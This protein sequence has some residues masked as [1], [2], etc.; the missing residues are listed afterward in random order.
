[1]ILRVFIMNT[2]TAQII[3]IGRGPQLSTS[4]ITVL[5]IFYY[6]HRGHDFEFVHEAMPRVS[7]EE[8]DLVLE[9]VKQHH[10]EL[11]EEDRQA[12]EFIRRGIEEQK[13]KGLYREIDESIPLE[14]RIAALKKKVRDRIKESQNGHAPH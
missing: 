14:E 11:V 8:F 1:M 3:D 13:A 6:L 9:Y 4:R 5:D 10:A 12:E 7:R 2:D